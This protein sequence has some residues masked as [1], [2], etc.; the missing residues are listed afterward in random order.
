MQVIVPCEHQTKQFKRIVSTILSQVTMILIEFWYIGY[1]TLKKSTVIYVAYFT[2][3]YGINNAILITLRAKLLRSS[4]V[5]RHLNLLCN[6]YTV[7]E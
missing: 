1:N 7:L 6:F 4:A 3:S 5:N 2:M